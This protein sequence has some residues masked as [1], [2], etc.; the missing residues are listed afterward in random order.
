MHLSIRPIDFQRRGSRRVAAAG[1]NVIRFRG[2]VVVAMSKM[3][4][5][6]VGGDSLRLESLRDV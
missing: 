3:R 1:W 6:R 5:L 4:N 2:R